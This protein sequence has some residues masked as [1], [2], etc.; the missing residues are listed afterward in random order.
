MSLTMIR[1]EEHVSATLLARLPDMSAHLS[2]FL[3]AILYTSS[4]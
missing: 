1:L 2:F 3:A 4:L